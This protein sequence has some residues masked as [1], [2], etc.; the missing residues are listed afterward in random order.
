MFGRVHI[1][2]ELSKRTMQLCNLP[3]HVAKTRAGKL[4]GRIKVQAQRSTYINVILHGEVKRTR[5]APAVLLNVVVFI[6]PHRH[7]FVRQVGNAH[8]KFGQAFT[9]AVEL[10]RQ[11]AQL[12]RDGCGFGHK[13]S[14]IFALA[15]CNTD[16]LGELVAQRLQFFRL[17]LHFLALVFQRVE[18][19]FGEV[20]GTRLQ[21]GDHFGKL[22]A[23][24][25]DIE[26][27]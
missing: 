2:H 22:L 25:I 24:H 18:F 20:E 14:G 3:F 6:A 19:L 12:F 13:L 10:S 8:Q 23:Q 15:L 27:F 9:H 11:S 16:L 26:H 4:G 7:G 17:G 21:A 1:K 5:R